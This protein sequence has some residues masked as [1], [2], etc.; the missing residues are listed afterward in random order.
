[1]KRIR[2]IY[3][4]VFAYIFR[5]ARSMVMSF[6]GGF[7]FFFLVFRVTPILSQML[8]PEVKRVGIVGQY[9]PETLPIPVQRLIGAGLTEIAENGEPKPG[10]ARSWEVTE[11]GKTYTF[12]LHEHLNWHDGKSFKAGDINYNINEVTFIPINDGTLVVKLKEPF[13]LLPVLLSRP[14]LRPGLIGLGPYKVT[15]LSLNADAIQSIRLTPVSRGLPQ[16]VL[17]FYLTEEQA[18]TAFKLG[19]VDILEDLSDASE[20]DSWQNLTITKRIDHTRYV[21]LFYNLENKILRDKAV[22][23]ALSFAVPQLDFEKATGPISPLSWAYS[24]KVRQYKFD[25]PAAGR[26]LG[27]KRG[28]EASGSGEL[29]IS[30]FLPYLSL[31]K[32]IAESWQNLGFSVNI[33]VENGIPDDYQVLLTSQEIPPDPDQ[34]PLWHST[35]KSTNITKLNNQKIDKL[36]EDGRTTIGKEDRLKIYT[37]FQRYLVDEAPVTF[38]FYPTVYTVSRK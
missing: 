1:M 3:W 14:L 16:L 37:D 36:L 20:F 10:L 31:A 7:F 18:K 21:A 28:E 8:L 34:Y 9:T 26:L 38:L 35:Q 11:E 32:R 30:T 27:N 33:R 13:V 4:F 29:T 25:L 6:V 22:R 24:N 17:R 19:E 12:I 23:Q 5:H 15:A 2:F